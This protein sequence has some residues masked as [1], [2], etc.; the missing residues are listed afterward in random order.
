MTPKYGYIKTFHY[1][2]PIVSRLKM[3]Y[4]NDRIELLT[5]GGAHCLE[6]KDSIEYKMLEHNKRINLTIVECN[7]KCVKRILRSLTRVKESGTLCLKYYTGFYKGIQV[8]VVKARLNTFLKKTQ[9]KYDAIVADFYNTF[10]K[11]NETAI[12]LIANRNLLNK[13]G[14]LS[15]TACEPGQAVHTNACQRVLE[16]N[17]D[18]SKGIVKIV[19]KIFTKAKQQV[20]FS[21]AWPYSNKDESSL[22]KLIYASDYVII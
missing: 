8:S 12:R 16:V 6:V 19:N 9:K 5:L 14:S 20:E 21:F 17:K 22:A 4:N 13:Y 3:R 1:R 11:E 15:L 18:Y 10:N 2:D 7:P